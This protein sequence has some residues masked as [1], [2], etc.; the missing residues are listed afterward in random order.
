MIP[1]P[2]LSTPAPVNGLANCKLPAVLSLICAGAGFKTEAEC[3]AL[4]FTTLG[5]MK[6]ATPRNGL[7]ATV[8]GCAAAAGVKA[9]PAGDVTAEAEVSPVV[10]KLEIVPFM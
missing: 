4:M 7:E 5:F 3:M 10:H 2:M 6:A 9:P 1:D 8:I